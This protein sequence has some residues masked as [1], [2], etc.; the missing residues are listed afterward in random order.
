MPEV[1]RRNIATNSLPVRPKNSAEVRWKIE[2]QALLKDSPLCD[3]ATPIPAHRGRRLDEPTPAGCDRI[4]PGRKSHSPGTTRWQTPA[5][6]RRSAH[7]AGAQSQAR[8]SAPPWEIGHTRH[9]RY[10]A[11]FRVLIAKK[12]TFAM[13]NPVGR[14]SVDAELEKLVIT[15]LQENPTWGSKRIVGALDNLGFKLSD[16]TVDNIRHRHGLDPAPLRGKSTRWHQFLQ[17][18][19]ETLIAA[20]FLYDGGIVLERV[21]H[22]LRVVR[23][24]TAV[25]RRS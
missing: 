24:R 3:D 4:P 21:G 14:P 13:T 16:S 6:H 19:W 11:W 15:L 2:P 10:P 8:R 5:L 25:T 9:S 20:D 17:S 22:L 7:P 23:H 1:K 18:H 12:W